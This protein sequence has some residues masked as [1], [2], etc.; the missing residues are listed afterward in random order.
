[1]AFSAMFYPDLNKE[2]H[3]TFAFPYCAKFLVFL[4]STYGNFQYINFLSLLSGW[5]K[6]PEITGSENPGE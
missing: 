3:V 5:K 4:G 2:K 1:M 6:L